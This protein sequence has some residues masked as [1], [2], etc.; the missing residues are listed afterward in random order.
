[1]IVSFA[2]TINLQQKG[3]VTYEEAKESTDGRCGVHE[4]VD[5]SLRSRSVRSNA[6]ERECSPDRTAMAKADVL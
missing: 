1:M 5:A 4:G 6:P 3:L 2:R